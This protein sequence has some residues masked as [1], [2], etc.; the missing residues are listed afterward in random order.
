MC[1]AV[2]AVV[3]IVFLLAIPATCVARK[4]PKDPDKSRTP[5]ERYIEQKKETEMAIQEIFPIKER[6][7]K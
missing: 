7:S 5:I 3:L 6:S 2:S 1:T 4:L